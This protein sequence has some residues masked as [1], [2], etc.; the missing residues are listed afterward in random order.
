MTEEED[1]DVWYLTGETTDGKPLRP[2]ATIDIVDGSSDPRTIRTDSTWDCGH[3]GMPN[4]PPDTSDRI[5]F[6]YACG[7]VQAGSMIVLCACGCV[8]QHDRPHDYV[9]DIQ[10]RGWTCWCGAFNGEETGRRE[11]CR[12]CEAARPM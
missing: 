10:L 11:A 12:T 7:A 6:A 8:R 9:A 4:D 3:C 5:A 1:S 2:F